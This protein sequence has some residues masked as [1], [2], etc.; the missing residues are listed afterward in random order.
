[1]NYILIIAWLGV[2]FAIAEYANVKKPVMI[3]GERVVRF[4]WYYALAVMIPVIIM[5][6][7]RGWFADTTAYIVGYRE[8]PSSWDGL[9]KYMDGVKRDRGFYFVSAVI[10]II[11]GNDYEPYLFI[12]ATL[13][14]VAIVFL[15][16]NYS[17]QYLFCIFL[18]L[19]STDY[20]SW[21]FN[22]MRQFTA[23]TIILFATPLMLKK[24][25]RLAILN[26]Y[27]PLFGIIWVASLFHQSALLMI[28]FVLICQGRAWN[29]RTLIFMVLAVLAVAFVNEFTDFLDDALQMTQYENVVTDYKE[30]KDDGTNPLRVLVYSVP[31]IIALVGIKRISF[32][33]NRLINFCVNMSLLSSAIYF[34][35]MVTSGIFIGRLPIYCSLFS[36][37]LLSWEID[38]IFDDDS[39]FVIYF[40]A[41][42]FYLIYYYYIMHYQFGI[43]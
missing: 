42:A 21:M 33:N 22:G 9:F 41:I 25:D 38:N 1:M 31:A 14:G 23:V 11:F 13:Q 37:I 39:K 16:R 20:I 29:A 19:A 8:M 34:V 4:K 5:A 15:F 30:W 35:S 27:L 24:D 3:G 26:K 6:T 2:C 7:K 10:H 43:I 32:E 18:F 17:R 12:F 36:Y 40:A 28:P